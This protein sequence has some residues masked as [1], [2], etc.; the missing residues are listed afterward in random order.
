MN[1]LDTAA[2]AAGTT[3]STSY[4][5]AFFMASPTWSVAI[6]GDRNF[7]VSK[8]IAANEVDEGG[9]EADFGNIE[10]EIMLACE[11]PSSNGRF[12]NFQIA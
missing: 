11:V 8:P 4:A 10:A 9:D 6:P 3:T 12:T 2:I 7:K 1:A 5:N